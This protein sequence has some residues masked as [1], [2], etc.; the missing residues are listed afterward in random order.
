MSLDVGT[1]RPDALEGTL[2]ALLN[3]IKTHRT[4][5]MSGNDI[6]ESSLEKSAELPDEEHAGISLW[7]G[8]GRRCGHDQ[9]GVDQLVG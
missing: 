3:F 8:S 2:G 9:E 1:D 4:D 6:L 5:L 7:N